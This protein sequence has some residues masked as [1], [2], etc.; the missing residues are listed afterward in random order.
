MTEPTDRNANGSRPNQLPLPDIEYRPTPFLEILARS[1]D[2]FAG[3]EGRPA[4]SA[5]PGLEA[6]AAL[7]VIMHGLLGSLACVANAL[8]RLRARD[9]VAEREFRA[10][11]SVMHTHL[12]HVTATLEDIVRG[13]PPDV[14]KALDDLAKGRVGR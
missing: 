3:S 7:A 14:V 9:G 12:A 1:A 10:L 6:D 13:S 4:V 11:T 8:D 2:R 5:E